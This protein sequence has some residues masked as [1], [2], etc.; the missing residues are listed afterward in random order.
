MRCRTPINHQIIISSNKA[1]VERWGHFNT[2]LWTIVALVAEDFSGT[3]AAIESKRFQDVPGL[4]LPK[5]GFNF[6]AST[7]HEV[8]FCS[9]I[10]TVQR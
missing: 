1:S 5:L 4:F 3:N 6:R 7:S 2:S 10:G 9:W 8:L